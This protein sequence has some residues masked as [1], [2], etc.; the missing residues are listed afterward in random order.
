MR[1]VSHC[2]LIMYPCADRLCTLC[3]VEATVLVS[4]IFCNFHSVMIGDNYITNGV[5][6][7]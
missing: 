2:S 7:F 5:A 6:M 3:G 4:M 1:F